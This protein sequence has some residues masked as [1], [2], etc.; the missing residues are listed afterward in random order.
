MT[1][2]HV[3][4]QLDNRTRLV[5]AVLAA[6]TY[7]E[8]SQDRQKHGTHLHARSTRKLVLEYAHH[9][10]VHALQVL[11]DKNVALNSIFGYALR[12]SW[13]ELT[14]DEPPRWVP[15]RW[16]EH[17]KHFYEVTGLAT[18]WADEDEQWQTA[19]QHLT[20]IFEKVDL[21]VFLEK[22][23]GALPETLA[24]VPN[25][26]YPTDLNVGCRVGGVLYALMPP[27]KAWGDSAPW[28]YDN[29]PM[30]MYQEVLRVYE[31]LLLASM[32]RQYAD[33]IGSLN[34][35][36]LPL[37]PKF[38]ERHT[39]WIDQFSTLFIA[40]SIALFLEEVDPRESKA[41]IQIQQ[42]VEGIAILP[43]VINLLRRY[44]DERK[45]GKYANFAEYLPN[46]TKNLRLV[47]TFATL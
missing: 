30:Y 43:G 27:R 5:S 31:D 19:V 3:Q 36:P 15:P 40:A 35:K 39:H 21:Y 10:A 1:A 28:P 32:T 4:V 37:G 26:S 29:D 22:F 46:F 12:L 24:L 23:F 14:G 9:P 18:W 41:F 42:R 34:D 47:K 45:A 2:R 20:E 17:L 33:T 44:Q 8:K 11:L 13:P 25:I 7:P 38:L 16:N 6:T